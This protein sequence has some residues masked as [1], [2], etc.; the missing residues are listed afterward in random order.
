MSTELENKTLTIEEF[1]ELPDDGNR[2]ELVVNGIVK[3]V[4]LDRGSRGV[5]YLHLLST[6]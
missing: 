3:G 5:P 1:M 6:S 4:V 2:Y